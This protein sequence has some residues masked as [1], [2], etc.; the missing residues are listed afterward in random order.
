MIKSGTITTPGVGE[1]RH[2]IM[3]HPL[4]AIAIAFAAGA[5]TGLA[6]RATREAAPTKRTIRSVLLGSVSA[7]V[8]GMI[9]S[10]VIEHLSGAAKSWLDPEDSASRDRSVESFLEH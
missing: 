5:I 4:A 3:A 10:A 8:M 7:I 9:R 1:L 2:T 6:G